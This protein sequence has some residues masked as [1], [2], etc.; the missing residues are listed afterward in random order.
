MFYKEK[1]LLENETYMHDDSGNAYKLKWKICRLNWKLCTV[2][3]CKVGNKKCD[4]A[5]LSIVIDPVDYITQRAGWTSGNAVDWIWEVPG[6]SLYWIWLKCFVL[7]CSHFRQI[8]GLN[9]YRVTS[10]P[11]SIPG[12]SMWDLW[13]LKWHRKKFFNECKV[14]CYHHLST[15]PPC[16]YFFIYPRQYIILATKSVVK[17]NVFLCC[18]SSP[19]DSLSVHYSSVTLASSTNRLP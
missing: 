18:C 1:R 5:G 17:S 12:H 19:S 3:S 9:C 11:G 2:E 6:L 8:K 10:V 16:L 7:L 13:Y 4:V 14:F 15:S